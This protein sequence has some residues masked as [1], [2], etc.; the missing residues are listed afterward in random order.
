MKIYGPYLRKDSRLVLIV[1]KDDGSKT[2]ISY[3]KW[4]MQQHLGRELIGDETVD[5]IDGNPL[6]NDLT[7]L[8][9]LSRSDNA[10]KS[11]N[12]AEQVELV[13][14]CCGIKFYRRTV[15]HNRNLSVRKTD[16]PFCSHRCVGKTYN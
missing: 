5:H 8:Q 15:V 11:V 3:P 7:N 16:G 2:T 14:K 12:Y 6:N 10:K 1:K 4:L 13:C 9:I